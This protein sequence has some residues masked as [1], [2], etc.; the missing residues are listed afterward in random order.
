MIGKNL[1]KMQVWASVNEADIA[2]IKKG[3]DVRFT[4][5][6]FP[7][8]DFTGKVE[9][10]RPNFTFTQ[11]VVTYTVIVSIDN[12]PS[13]LMPYLTANLKF[14]VETRPNVL[15][16][17]N[18]ALRWKPS[19]DMIAPRQPALAQIAKD[20]GRRGRLWVKDPDG[21]HVRPIEVQVGETDG[22]LIEISGPDVKE[23]MEAVIGALSADQ[24]S[25]DP[26]EPLYSEAD[27]ETCWRLGK[28]TGNPCDSFSSQKRAGLRC[29]A[30]RQPR[31]GDRSP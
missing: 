12:P 27:Q 6:A 15:R 19:P 14:L 11:N 21:T 29:H 2:L 4:V 24:T 31:G 8:E 25:R 22:T 30:R 13:K 1:D 28:H 16:V 26:L 5:D 10:I 3:M 9:Q 7:K 20:H 18:A 23:G 17:A